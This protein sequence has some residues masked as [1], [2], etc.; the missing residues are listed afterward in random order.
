MSHLF[1]SR[2]AGAAALGFAALFAAACG[3]P[4]APGA[5][6]IVAGVSL[7]VPPYPN[8]DPFATTRLADV[9]YFEVCKDY[10]EGSGPDVTINVSVNVGNDADATNDV[11]LT[12]VTLASGTCRDVWLVGGS[13]GDIVTVSEVVPTGYTASYVLQTAVGSNPTTRTT[14][15][16]VAGSSA[17]GLVRGNTGQLVIFTNTLIPTGG[18]GCTPGYWK[19][20]QHFDSWSTYTPGQLAG[21]VFNLGGFPTLASKTLVATLGGTGGPGTLGAASI[22]LR[23]AVAA[24]LN[25]ESAGVDYTQ[26]TADII[27]DV[28]AALASNDRATMLAL[29]AEL[30][31]D[32]NLGCPLN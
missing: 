6:P 30:D 1:R 8:T 31:A 18:E 13:V 25:A 10:A 15:A 17:S 29:A 14:F 16:S 21:S 7:N 12:P 20:E 27:A 11:A 5:T 24:I 3:D 28:N 32:N 4:S 19:Q 22:L 26:V 23:A 9:E 2:S